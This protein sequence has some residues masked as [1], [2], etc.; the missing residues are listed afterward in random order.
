[1]TEVLEQQARWDFINGWKVEPQSNDRTPPQSPVLTAV[2]ITTVS[3]AARRST[4]R[5]KHQQRFKAWSQA[6]HD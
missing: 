2:A 4:A 3:P 5:R 6:R 1:M